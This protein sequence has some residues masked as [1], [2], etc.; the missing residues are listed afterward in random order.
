MQNYFK[1]KKIAP[2]IFILSFSTATS[3]LSI[4]LAKNNLIV[5]KYFNTNSK[6][7]LAN[8]IPQIKKLLFKNKLSIKDIN[9]IATIKG[10]GSFTGIRIALATLKGL[11]A[12]I[13]SKVITFNTF[14]VMSYPYL[15]KNKVVVCLVRAARNKFFVSAYKNKKQ[16]IKLNNNSFTLEEISKIF[17]S[18]PELIIVGSLNKAEK[19][20]LK[21]SLAKIEFCLK[22]FSHPLAENIC[23]LA[24]K[25]YKNKIS[26]DI[27]KIKPM[28]YLLSQAEM[29]LKE[30]NKN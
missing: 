30:K 3:A 29:K 27:N 20:F 12:T 1:Q 8:L 10:P 17:F 16:F 24:Y 25:K 19:L 23:L 2:K 15:N 28:Y 11:A 26:E 22:K 6:K 7:S 13:N 21:N 4:A 14:E 18:Q 5:D 9:L